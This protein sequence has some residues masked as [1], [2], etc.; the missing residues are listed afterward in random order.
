MATPPRYLF[1]TSSAQSAGTNT[2]ALFAPASLSDASITQDHN[3]D[4]I[5]LDPTSN[6]TGGSNLGQ[7]LR[8]ALLWKK[9][10]D[11]PG[12]PFV[13]FTTS[14][15][16]AV[17]LAMWRSQRKEFKDGSVLEADEDVR[18][19]IVDKQAATTR[20]GE[21][22]T[23]R[24]V[25]ELIDEYA[26]D[27]RNRG[28]DARRDYAGQWVASTEVQLGAG[29]WQ[30]AFSALVKNGL[31]ELYPQVEVANQRKDPRICLG[32][33]DLRKFGFGAVGRGWGGSGVE[34]AMDTAGRVALGFEGCDGGDEEGAGMGVKLAF[35]LALRERDVDDLAF[36]K[37]LRD[38]TT[39]FPGAGVHHGT[40]VSVPSLED[41]G[42]PDAAHF[43]FLQKHFADLRFEA[44][45]LA[46]GL[47]ILPGAIEKEKQVWLDWWRRDRE[48]YRAAH[49]RGQQQGRKTWRERRAE[50]KV[51]LSG[52]RARREDSVVQPAT[53]LRRE[54]PR[55]LFPPA[56]RGGVVRE[57]FPSQ[58]HAAY[59]QHYGV[60][61]AYN[62][63]HPDTLQILS[64]RAGDDITTAY[65]HRDAPAYS[66]R[67]YND[68]RS[69]AAD[70][71]QQQRRQPGGLQVLSSRPG[72][73]VT[74]QHQH[75]HLRMEGAG[76]RRDRDRE[77]VVR[78]R[79]W[80]GG[81]IGY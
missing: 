17:Q 1:R 43:Q 40:A 3:A 18:I 63:R 48:E 39:N 57:L 5:A 70:F 49:P 4:F 81:E 58:R 9:S 19:T 59:G 6:T 25:K 56:Q 24:S 37:W 35:V 67:P 47:P 51:E 78:R 73:A 52:R 8:Q 45:G 2:S 64:S 66:S 44:A 72:D 31:F 16:F 62:P 71:Q 12:C 14:P 50:R 23:F 30:V 27:I 60:S 29:C 38:H 13:F 22:V 69:Y 11:Q 7:Q 41:N 61:T 28:D 75:R 55:E 77:P 32:S 42:I 36:A 74:T 21:P 26:L 33:K 65:Q 80:R 15:V 34:A 20:S 79:G 46:V 54:Q 68:A 10:P 53:P 76:R